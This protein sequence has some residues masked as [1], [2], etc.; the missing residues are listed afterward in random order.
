MQMTLFDLRARHYAFAAAIFILMFSNL[1]GYALQV[2]VLG[3]LLLC[4]AAALSVI[5]TLKLKLFVTGFDFIIFLMLLFSFISSVMN[6]QQYVVIYT[7]VFLATYLAIAHLSR[8][9]TDQE[10]VFCIVLAAMMT[11]AVVAVTN[12]GVLWQTLQPGDPNR[13]AHRFRPFNMHPNLTGYVYGGFITISLFS[14]VI[15]GRLNI[16]FKIGAIAIC[17]M[18]SLASSARAGLVALLGVAA[19]YVSR[20]V[21]L[22]G[23]NTK[24]VIIGVFT[25]ALLGIVFE[26]KIVHYL[27]HIL[28]LSSPTRGLDSGGTGRLAI[29]Q[30]GLSVISE[31]TWEFYI[32]SGLRSSEEGILGFFTE[33]SYI[34]I[35]IDSGVF[36]VILFVGYLLRLLISLHFSERRNQDQFGRLVFYCAVFALLQSIF[37]RYLLAI[38][39]PFSL[40]FLILISKISVNQA[41]ARRIAMNRSRAALWQGKARRLH[42]VS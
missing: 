32:G 4:F 39:N 5:Q 30:R 25:V 37:N 40:I 15:S 29:W 9:M 13:W 42:P 27:T 24:Y 22:Q 18:I 36:V 7:L 26:E 16:L 1:E 21:M 35:C 23:K 8:A 38:G 19:V 6:Q 28:E 34:S 14:N 17:I 31:R 2:Q 3:V 41:V 20:S 10:I 12:L 33:N 11:I